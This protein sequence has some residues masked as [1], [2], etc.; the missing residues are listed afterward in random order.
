MWLIV[1]IFGMKLFEDSQGASIE[2][3]EHFRRR[4]RLKRSIR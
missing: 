3:V 4:E 2:V 1:S